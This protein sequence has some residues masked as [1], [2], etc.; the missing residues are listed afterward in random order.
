MQNTLLNCALSELTEHHLLLVAYL[1]LPPEQRH[2][3][4]PYILGV[5]MGD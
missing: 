4:I 5:N 2:R 1:E 3:R